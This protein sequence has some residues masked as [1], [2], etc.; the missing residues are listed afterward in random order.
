MSEKI[1][2]LCAELSLAAVAE[3]Y[4]NLADEAAKKKRSF[5]EYLEQ[6]LRAES[7]LCGERRRQ[8]LTKLAGFPAVRTLEEFDS[9]AAPS[10]MVRESHLEPSARRT[11]DGFAARL[12]CDRAC[13]AGTASMRRRRTNMASN[14]RHPK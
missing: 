14:A 13:S 4:A 8:T 2:A 6:L 11:Q 3:Q 12:P 1:E 9:D 7:Q 10:G 5:V